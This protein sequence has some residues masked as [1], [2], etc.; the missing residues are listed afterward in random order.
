MRHGK[1]ASAA[2]TGRLAAAAVIYLTASR[3]K[4][5]GAVFITTITTLILSFNFE[6]FAAVSV[7]RA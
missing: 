4:L 6:A 1:P 2:T 7:R 3:R 5:D